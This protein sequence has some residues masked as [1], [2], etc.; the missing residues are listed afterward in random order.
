MQL[1][2]SCILFMIL[3]INSCCWGTIF[4][5]FD[6]PLNIST[7]TIATL[8]ILS[9]TTINLTCWPW[10]TITSDRSQKVPYSLLIF[11]RNDLTSGCNHKN[12]WFRWQWLLWIVS[13]IRQYYR[14]CY[15]IW[16]RLESQGGVWLFTPLAFTQDS[17]NWEI[18]GVEDVS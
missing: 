13:C 6:F 2:H 18:W 4:Y 17:A 12:I 15:S 1:C 11:Q 9:P 14:S 5:L 16:I 7:V 8:R 3:A 10:L